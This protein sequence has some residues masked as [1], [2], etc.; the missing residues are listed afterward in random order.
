MPTW[1]TTP[2]TPPGPSPEV[3]PEVPD[4]PV[5]EVP[6]PPVRRGG[7]WPMTTGT[8][9]ADRLILCGFSLADVG[10]HTG[11]CRWDMNDYL[12]R[13]RPISPNH[14]I[15]LCRFLHCEPEAIYE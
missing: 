6:D 3:P 7:G 4:P 8:K 9:L 13:R 12:N 14:L 2:P 11:I 1:P 15:R 5:P 10:R